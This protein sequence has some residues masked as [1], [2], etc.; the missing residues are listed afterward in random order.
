MKTL[1]SKLVKVGIKNGYTV[2]DFCNKYGITGEEEFLSQLKKAFPAGAEQALREIRK[3]ETHRKKKPIIVVNH[4]VLMSRKEEVSKVKEQK[5][6]EEQEVDPLA[7]LKSTESELSAQVIELESRHK[8][9]AS[10]RKKCLSEL[11]EIQEKVNEFRAE[12]D[13][14]QSVYKEVAVEAN[15]IIRQMN[16][17]SRDRADK[18]AELASV[19]E[20]IAKLETT[21]IAVCNDG[22]F[23]V[24][25]GAAISLD[26]DEDKLSELSHQLIDNSICEEL[27]AKQIKALARLMTIITDNSSRKVEFIFDSD[28]ADLEKAYLALKPL[29][30]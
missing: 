16:G 15:R 7:A 28:H 4:A 12:I 30:P 19:R 11:R 25:E 17:V 8:Q 29:S 22:K 23:E 13:R 6:K 10:E 1:T 9:L 21:T 18:Q 5:V 26:I 2:E 20:Q 14:Q 24:V 27:K 3:N